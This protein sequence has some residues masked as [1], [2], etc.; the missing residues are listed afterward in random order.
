MCYVHKT[1]INSNFTIIFY[2][3]S[4]VIYEE[5]KLII[6]LVSRMYSL[7]SNNTLY[8][9]ALFLHTVLLS[10]YYISLHCSLYTVSR[11]CCA[12]KYFEHSIY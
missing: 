1:L 11:H 3:T 4:H 12:N 10:I 8:F 5:K 2:I 6:V 7:L 9:Y